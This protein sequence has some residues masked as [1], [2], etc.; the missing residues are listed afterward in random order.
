[1][2]KTKSELLQ[3]AINTMEARLEK[4][5]QDVLKDEVTLVETRRKLVEEQTKVAEKETK[6][7]ENADKPKRKS[8]KPV[9]YIPL[10]VLA[11]KV[12]DNLQNSGGTFVVSD[13]NLVELKQNAATLL[14]LA[15]QSKLLGNQ[16]KTNTDGLEQVNTELNAAVSRLKADLQSLHGKTN[17]DTLYSNYGLDMERSN[18]YTLSRDNTLR[19][20]MLNVLINKLQEAGN[21]IQNW[22]NYNLRNWF[23]L[24][25]RHTQLW[26]DSETLR[27][28][29]STN[30]NQL[31]PIYDLVEQ[32][33]KKINRYVNYAFPKAQVRGKLRELGFLKES[34]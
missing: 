15:N 13:V 18:Y 8:T 22:P 7:A 34:F 10:A 2:K 28:A 29:R 4:K 24:Q 1:M 20:K 30:T 17:I 11:D 14:Q 12:A 6:A 16:K 9:G 33:V 3:S 5:K 31:T 25:Q 21:P 23:D 32:A 26:Q 27:S 19:V